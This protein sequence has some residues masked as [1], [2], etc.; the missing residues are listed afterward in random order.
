MTTNDTR[1]REIV[2]AAWNAATT[3][4]VAGTKE[5]LPSLLRDELCKRLSDALS[6]ARADAV[7]PFVE[8]LQAIE[9]GFPRY[10]HGHASPLWHNKVRELLGKET[11]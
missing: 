2:D 1:A 8:L 9:A 11:R 4:G 7:M 6:A 5:T 10:Y 3:S